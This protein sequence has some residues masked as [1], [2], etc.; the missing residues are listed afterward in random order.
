MEEKVKL[1]DGSEVT[2]QCIPIGGRKAFKL[3]KEVLNINEIKSGKDGEFS[4]KCEMNSAV[5]VCW[6]YIVADCPQKEKI[7]AEDMQRIYEK[8]AKKEMD[9]VVKK[10]LEN[11]KTQ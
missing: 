3:G 8:Y 4:A 1:N 2:I 9:F 7:C 10:N 5:D 6:N 11:F